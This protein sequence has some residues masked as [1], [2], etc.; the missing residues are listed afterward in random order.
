MTRKPRKL[1]EHLVSGKLLAHAYGCMGEIATC[2]GFFAYFVIMNL[3]GFKPSDLIGLVS[4]S[5][6]VPGGNTDYNTNFTNLNNNA[7]DAF[8]TGFNLD[9]RK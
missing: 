7:S 8:G 2:G 6:Y 3:Y 5:V 4:R 9:C 1:D